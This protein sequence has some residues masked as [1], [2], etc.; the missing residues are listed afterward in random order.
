MSATSQ[1]R[2]LYT[3]SGLIDV[4]VDV[5]QR[6]ICF[7]EYLIQ[8]IYNVD[9]QVAH[10]TPGYIVTNASWNVIDSTSVFS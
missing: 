9:I 8:R 4:R 3:Q 10:H 6:H 5:T 7:E 1:E 2:K